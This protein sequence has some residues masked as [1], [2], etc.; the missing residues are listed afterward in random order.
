M[1]TTIRFIGMSIPHW[2]GVRISPIFTTADPINIDQWSML[3]QAAQ[4]K[5]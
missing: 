1:Y 5:L 3:P 2:S 4:N